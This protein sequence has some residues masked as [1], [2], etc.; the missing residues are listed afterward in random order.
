M[1]SGTIE[2]ARAK[3]IW[4][5]IWL[6]NMHI[7]ILIKPC[8]SWICVHKLT[9]VMRFSVSSLRFTST[10]Q[11]LADIRSVHL[12]ESTNLD[13]FFP[14]W[15]KNIRQQEKSVSIGSRIFSLNRACSCKANPS[16]QMTVRSTS[17]LLWSKH[18]RERNSERS[19]IPLN[20]MITR[21]RRSC[22]KASD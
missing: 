8:W 15:R 13:T 6:L 4:L 14:W 1:Q 19:E 9:L 17:L 12:S 21:E 7:V 2:V 18:Q 10:S 5:I 22:G 3:R 11:E 16:L 20:M